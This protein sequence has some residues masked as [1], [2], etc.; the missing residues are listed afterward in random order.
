MRSLVV[1]ASA[2]L[3]YLLG[4]PGAGRAETMIE[5]RTDVLVPWLFWSEVI[6]SLARRQRWPGSQVL[7]AVYDL[8]QLGVR[9][10]APSRPFMLAAIDAVEAH[11]LSA[12]DAEYLVLAEAANADLLTGDAHLAAAVGD[13]AIL[14]ERGHRPAEEVSPYVRGDG[15]RALDWPSWPGAAGYLEELRREVAAE[16]DRAVGPETAP[17]QA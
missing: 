9:T 8:E 16:V 4:E 12:Y 11:G 17:N 15:R 3:A 7:S 1:D 6:N 5:Q 13:R 2:A 10:E 14:I